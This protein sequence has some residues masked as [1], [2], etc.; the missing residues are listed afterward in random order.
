MPIFLDIS[1]A[2]WPDKI[3]LPHASVSTI[4]KIC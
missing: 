2:I 1:F 3:M 4:S